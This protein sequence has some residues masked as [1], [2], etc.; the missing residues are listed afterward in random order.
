M[1]TNNFIKSWK[2]GLCCSKLTTSLVD[3][4]LKFTSSDT[5]ICWNVL[6]KQ[7]WVAFAVQKLLNIFSAKHI[8]I[9]HIESAKTVNEMTLYELVKPTTLWTA[10]PWAKAVNVNYLNLCARYSFFL[11]LF[12]Y[13]F[14][15]L[16][17]F[18]YNTKTYEKV[19][20]I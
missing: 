6:L 19:L 17:Y 11:I 18:F 10:G 16:F 2:T 5:Q 8:R 3:D 9:L 1:L 14:F 13:F 15:I 7:M 12:I 20:I 4:S